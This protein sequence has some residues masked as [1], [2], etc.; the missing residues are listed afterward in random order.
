M[1]GRL[2]LILCLLVGGECLRSSENQTESNKPRGSTR[3]S[4]GDRGEYYILGRFVYERNCLICHGQRG[5]GD[6]EWSSSLIPRPRSFKAA[7]FKYRT[8]PFG[9]L[10]TDDDLRRTIRGG[11]SNTAMG[12]FSKLKERELEAVIVYIKTFSRKWRDDDYH[13]SVI[14]LPEKPAWFDDQEQRAQRSMNGK[15]IF[16]IACAPCHGL[17][18]DGQGAQA[19]TLKDFLGRSISPANLLQPHLR[20]G[21][22]EFDLIRVLMTGLNG[23]PMLSFAD[24]LTPQEMW[25]LTAFLQGKRQNAFKSAAALDT[26]FA[27]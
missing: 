7:Q 15:Q 23:T 8:T 20:N 26:T 17:K 9:K 27:P 21:N 6:G 16:E 2:I 22:S 25:E 11:R 1:R 14:P 12:M 4:R 13:A 5:D 18:G 10:P 19:E 3:L 24:A